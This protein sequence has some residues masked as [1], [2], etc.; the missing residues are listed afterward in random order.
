MSIYTCMLKIDTS[1]SIG[2]HNDLE[3]RIYPT[4]S[5]SSPTHHHNPKRKHTHLI[6]PPI[7]TSPHLFSPLQTI[8]PAQK[9][10][11]QIS[12]VLRGRV[13]ETHDE[14]CVVYDLEAGGVVPVASEGCTELGPNF[15]V[16]GGEDADGAA[17]DLRSEDLV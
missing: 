2:A 1:C 14:E 8:R 10:T 4:K 16:F 11:T 6:I 13:V 15:P 5:A 17:G 12:D 9:V 3:L 7:R